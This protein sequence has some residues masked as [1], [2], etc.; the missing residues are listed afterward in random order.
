MTDT[1]AGIALLWIFFAVLAPK[2]FGLNIGT[3]FYKWK[4]GWE[5]AR[6]ALAKGDE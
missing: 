2:T 1:L 4:A 6:R 3:L 5:E